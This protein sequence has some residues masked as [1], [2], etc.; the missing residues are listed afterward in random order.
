G[1]GQCSAHGR[2][3]RVLLYRLAMIDR[4]SPRTAAALI[5]AIGV[6]ALAA[7]FAFQ[8][9]GGLAPCILCIWQRYPYAIAIGL[10]ALAFALAGRPGVAR[11]LIAL[12]GLVLLADAAIAAFHVGVEQGWWQGTAGCGSTLD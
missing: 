10:G 3:D 12:A 1:P 8:H 7:A 5:V 2:R 6:F 4:I 9:L 11:A